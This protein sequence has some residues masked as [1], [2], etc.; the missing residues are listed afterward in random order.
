MCEDRVVVVD[1]A[2]NDAS[3]NW[4]INNALLGG[5]SPRHVQMRQQQMTPQS[6]KEV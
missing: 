3:E 5:H 1:V 2:N 6:D 4:R